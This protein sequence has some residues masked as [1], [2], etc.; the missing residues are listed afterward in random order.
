[1]LIRR[2]H[3]PSAYQEGKTLRLPMMNVLHRC[4]AA[5]GRPA[6]A[7][8]GAGAFAKKCAIG[9]FDENNSY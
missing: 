6:A 2:R 9:Y 4:R 5:T 1:M 3:D 7:L 8:R